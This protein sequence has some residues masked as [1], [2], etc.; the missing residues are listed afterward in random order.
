MGYVVRAG[1]PRHDERC[2][3]LSKFFVRLGSLRALIYTTDRGRCGR[4]RT[5]IHFME[6]PPLLACDARG[7]QLYIIGGQY[8]VT[9]RGIE[10]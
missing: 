9:P 10:G 4:P 8:R 3:S 1:G 2:P 5:Y 7:R 6:T